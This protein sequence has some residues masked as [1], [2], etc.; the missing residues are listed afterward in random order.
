MGIKNN[1]YEI[2]IL[3]PHLDDA[4]LSL[5]SHIAKWK[6]EGKKIRII[7]VFTKF[8]NNKNI[9][10]YSKDYIKRSGFDSVKKF[11]M[12]RN[13][14][15]S[16][17][18]KGLGVVYEHWDFIDAG[19]RGV[20]KTKETLLSGNINKKD[21]NMLNNIEKK[22][23]ELKADLLM[24]PFGVGGHVDHVIL[25]EAVSKISC[26]NYYL[27]EPYLWQNFNFLKHIWRIIKAESVIWN[28]ND[29]EKLLRSYASQYNLLVKDNK[30]FTEVII[31]GV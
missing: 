20:Y 22:V 31:R 10:D 27:E 2:V 9:P 16:V 12:A 19:F 5:G 30:F 28:G 14:E 18:M 23:S 24:V 26:K 1:E 13:K 7:T 25:K 15:D 8:I 21:K 29:K 3:S 17:V 4:V 11:E 6:N